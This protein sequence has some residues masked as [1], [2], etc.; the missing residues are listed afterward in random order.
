LKT[1]YR[2]GLRHEG[3]RHRATAILNHD[4]GRSENSGQALIL[5]N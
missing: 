3:T 4:V 2:E 5:G 1:E